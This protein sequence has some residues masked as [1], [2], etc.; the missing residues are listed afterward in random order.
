MKLLPHWTLTG[1]NPAFYD[2]ESA[3]AIEQTAKVYGA[4]QTLIEEY[5]T[6]AERMEKTIEDF[7]QDTNT[8]METF[9]VGIR[10]EFQDFIDVVDMRLQQL[11]SDVASTTTQMVNDA[12]NSGKIKV[13]EVYDGTSESLN[14]DVTGGV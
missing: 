4:M 7:I 11:E 9:K 8:D 10:Q 6:F 1:S 2:T 12:I 14:L 3:T 5:N 13:T